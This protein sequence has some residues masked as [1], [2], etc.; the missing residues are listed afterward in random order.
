MKKI[1]I[2]IAGIILSMNLM[3]AGIGIVDKQE[4]FEKYPESQKTVEYLEK[5]KTEF[6]EVLKG[7]E[8]KLDAKDKEIAKKGDK[9]TKAEKDELDK[10]KVERKSKFEAMQ[11]NLDQLQYNLYDKISSDIN[12]AIAETAKTK[13]LDVVID[14][15]TAYYGGEDITKDVLSFLSGVKKIDLK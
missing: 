9:A 12:V 10:M 8:S 1:V 5:K 14:K 4:V 11:Q 3:A 15:T 2:G 6:E 13:N 7:I